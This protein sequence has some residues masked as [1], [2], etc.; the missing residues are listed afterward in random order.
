MATESNGPKDDLKATTAEDGLSAT[1]VQQHPGNT[2]GTLSQVW[3]SGCM[4][5]KPGSWAV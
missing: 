3:V 4:R 1:A 5:R 2:L